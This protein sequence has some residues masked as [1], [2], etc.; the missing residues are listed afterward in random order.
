MTNTKKALAIVNKMFKNDRYSQWLGIEI[1]AVDAGTCTLQMQISSDML[2]G[3]GIAHGGISYAF[4]DSA[5]AFASN[6]HG[7]K[8]VS[9]ETAISHLQAIK[10]GDILTAQ[11]IEKS[12]QPRIAVYEVKVTNQAEELVA[13]FKGTV[14]RKREE[15]VIE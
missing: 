3:F 1:I 11:A 8:A 15:W 6:A 9:I 12:K 2:N 7:Q 4:A 5:L 13:L 14:Y 10:L